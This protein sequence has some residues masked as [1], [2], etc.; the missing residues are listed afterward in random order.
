SVI[1]AAGKHATCGLARLQRKPRRMEA[2][3]RTLHEGSRAMRSIK[4][5]GA[6]AIASLA[7][8]AFSASASG[9]LPLYLKSEGKIVNKGATTGF[10]YVVGL[11]FDYCEQDQEGALKTNGKSK[12]ESTLSSTIKPVFC[13]G[14]STGG[15]F[16]EVELTSA[17]K[18]V[19]KGKLTVKLSPS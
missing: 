4:V 1:S 13:E 17:G 11:P 6:C 2:P 5:L 9:A 14:A 10:Y 15:S 7:L 3:R 12:D 16:K 8:G 19:A 18:I